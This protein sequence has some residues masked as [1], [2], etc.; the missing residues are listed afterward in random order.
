MSEPANGHG[1]AMTVKE[2][3]L[4]VHADMKVV[5]PAVQALQQLDVGPRLTAL[6]REGLI[7][8][9]RSKSIVEVLGAGKTIVLLAFSFLG[10][11]IAII[12]WASR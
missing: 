2:L 11:A 7:Q 1:A 10:A 3:L 9:A 8:A 4:E 5:R 12:G 6:E